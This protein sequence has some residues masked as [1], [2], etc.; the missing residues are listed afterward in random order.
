VSETS[1]SPGLPFPSAHPGGKVHLT[2]A[3][4]AR[5]V[6]PPGFG[7]PLDGFLPSCPC[8]LCFTPA[9]LLGFTLRSL[10]QNRY[11]D[12]STWKDPPTV[13]PAVSP[14][15][16]SRRTA[17]GRYARPRLLGFHP[18]K[19]PWHRTT[20]L[21]RPALDAPLGFALLGFPARTLRGIPPATPPMCFPALPDEKR[22]RHSGVSIG[23]SLARLTR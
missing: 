13:S 14:R 16:C 20:W 22:Q 9:A 8:Q 21:A 23:P 11:P 10:T 5:Y 3:L 7:Y 6:P 4:P 19:S 1:T 15:R 12:V 18:P 2:R 17:S